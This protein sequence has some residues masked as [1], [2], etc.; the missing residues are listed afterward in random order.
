M[1]ECSLELDRLTEQIDDV[2]GR[3]DSEENPLHGEELSTVQEQLI[4]IYAEYRRRHEHLRELGETLDKEAEDQCPNTELEETPNAP[5]NSTVPKEAGEALPNLAALSVSPRHAP[6]GD[7]ANT[8]PPSS[9]YVASPWL[10]HLAKPQ[11]YKDGDDICLFFTRISQ[12]LV[13]SRCTEPRKD[14]IVLNYIKDDKMYRK[15]AAVT[16]TKEE[17]NDVTLLVA[18]LSRA[19]FPATE[20]R[21]MRSSLAALKQ[22][23]G[24]SVEDFAMKI[25]ETSDKAYS[26]PD[27]DKVK[28]EAVL[29]AFI[30]GVQ[31]GGVFPPTFHF[32]HWRI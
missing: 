20:A 22:K 25:R 11:A 29:S 31:Y 13:L 14:L 19:L 6:A 18:A 9:G 28:E 1:Y 23:S 16:L 27:A 10:K 26:G 12:F 17:K 32:F 3:I 21:L 15:L 7:A 8:P 5:V 2:Q 30:A 24:E 4:G